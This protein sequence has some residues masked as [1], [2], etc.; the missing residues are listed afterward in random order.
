MNLGE[1]WAN[2]TKSYI[3][4]GMSEAVKNEFTLWNSSYLQRAATKED[5]EPEEQRAQ[6]S[7]TC[8]FKGVV[9]HYA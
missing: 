6:M 3:T 9:K 2:Y 1:T 8:Y 5:A 7:G 4:S